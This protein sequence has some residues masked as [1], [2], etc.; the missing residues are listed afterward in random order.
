[1]FVQEGTLE[2]LELSPQCVSVLTQFSDKDNLTD[3]IDF[4]VTLG[5]DGTLIHASSLFQVQ[6]FNR[7]VIGCFTVEIR[8]PYIHIIYYTGN[9][10]LYKNK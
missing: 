4:I 6:L 9:S 5:G 1:M 8:L 3:R 10:D 2:E 7:L